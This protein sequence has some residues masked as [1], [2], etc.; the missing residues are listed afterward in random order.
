MVDKNLI[1]Q[2]SQA[3]VK[4][5]KIKLAYVLGSVVSGKLKLDSDFDLA[6]VVD[7]KDKIDFKF[8]YSLIS[9]IKFPK[10]LD[11]SI[12]DKNSSP[13]FLFQIAST[14][15]CIYRQSEEEKVAFEA[16]VLKNYYDTAHMRSIYYSYL[17]DKFHHANQ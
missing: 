2:I 5:P 11:L 16:F 8:V 1:L 17:K 9:H 14:G 13:L 10:N 15:E 12:V 7:N 6:I 4:E 3:L